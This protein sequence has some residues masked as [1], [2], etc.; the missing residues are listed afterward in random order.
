MIA[1]FL[2]EKEKGVPSHPE[3]N[4]NKLDRFFKLVQNFCVPDLTLLGA[5]RQIRVLFGSPLISILSLI[6]GIILVGGKNGK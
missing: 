2:R 5:R 4:P 1:A 6:K 3:L